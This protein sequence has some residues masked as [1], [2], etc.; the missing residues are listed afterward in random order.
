MALVESISS[1]EK[2]TMMQSTS[3]FLVQH[4]NGYVELQLK[5]RST[6]LNVLLHTK[7]HAPAEKL[8]RLA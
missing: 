7:W 5:D 4:S 8:G 2:I 6:C 3:T 1:H